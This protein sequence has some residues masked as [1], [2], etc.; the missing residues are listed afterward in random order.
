[1]PYKVKR[2]GCRYTQAHCVSNCNKVL[3][4]VDESGRD[5]NALANN[6]T[7]TTETEK[8]LKS[9]LFATKDTTG[10]F[11]MK[12]N[13]LGGSKTAYKTD[14]KP[15]DPNPRQGPINYDAIWDFSAK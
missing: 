10:L 11:G 15:Q 12:D 6:Y 1:M 7:R 8:Y 2:D 5:L 4:E 14:Y 13:R 9:R 3:V